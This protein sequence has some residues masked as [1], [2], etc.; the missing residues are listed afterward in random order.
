LFLNLIGFGMAGVIGWLILD[1]GGYVPTTFTNSYGKTTGISTISVTQLPQE[2]TTYVLS[3]NYTE[4]QTLNVVATSCI[5][6]FNL[7]VGGI[8]YVATP[9][10]SVFADTQCQTSAQTPHELTVKTDLPM[11]SPNINIPE[12]LRD[13]KVT[14]TGDHRGKLVNPPKPMPA[15][16]VFMTVVYVVIVLALAVFFNE[17]FYPAFTE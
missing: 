17:E 8:T 10:T 5:G 14:Y 6:T 9:T 16:W 15:V 4:V 13:L 11:Q 1:E 7:E 2:E 12:G 3:L